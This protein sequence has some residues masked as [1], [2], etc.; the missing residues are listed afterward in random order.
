M[1]SNC[2]CNCLIIQFALASLNLIQNIQIR[3]ILKEP[4]K[5]KN[6]KWIMPILLQILLLWGLF[7]HSSKM[8]HITRYSQHSFLLKSKHLSCHLKQTHDAL[9]PEELHTHN[10]TLNLFPDP[11]DDR[12]TALGHPVL[13]APLARA[14][15]S[16]C[17][18]RCHSK[19]MRSSMPL[20]VAS[21]WLNDVLLKELRRAHIYSSLA[22]VACVQYKCKYQ[23]QYKCKYQ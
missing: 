11:D 6:R 20:S 17:D 3:W 15:Q 18:L 5:K 7:K 21:S 13:F 12:N 22:W 16:R 2:S 9:M 10:K 8:P 19:P 14:R 1:K 4:P 23:L